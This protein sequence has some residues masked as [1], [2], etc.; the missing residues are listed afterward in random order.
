MV[1]TLGKTRLS[2]VRMAPLGIGL[3]REAITDNAPTKN[4]GGIKMRG[5]DYRE[6]QKLERAERQRKKREG[7]RRRK[8]ARKFCD[9]EPEREYE[10]QKDYEHTI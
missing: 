4:F 1:C 3:R 5:R 10:T 8:N 9:H 2:A 6:T 7:M